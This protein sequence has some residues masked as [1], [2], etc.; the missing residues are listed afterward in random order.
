[1]RGG[2]ILQG[3]FVWASSA[4][5]LVKGRKKKLGLEGAQAGGGKN[6]LN[7]KL[8]S[9]QGL[10]FRMEGKLRD[11]KEGGGNIM[12]PLRGKPPEILSKA[13]GGP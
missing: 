7:H 4:L 3:F 13:W 5:Y 8:T 9:L 2:K 6:P 1:L 12:T 10:A 11:T